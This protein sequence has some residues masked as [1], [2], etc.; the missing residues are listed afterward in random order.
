MENKKL[1]IGI[2]GGTFDPIH[3]GHLTIAEQVRCHFNL[4]KVLFVPT[5][6]PPHKDINN[7]TDPFH[8]LNMVKCAIGSNPYFEAVDIE[9]KREG[10][11]F[12]VDTLKQ[13]NS[14]YSTKAQFYYIIGADVV[15]DLLT[16]RN[17]EEVFRLTEFIAVMRPGFSNEEFDSQIK[18]LKEK[19]N[20]KLTTFQAP[21]IEISSTGI[22]DLITKKQSIKYM[23]P[24]C[25][26]DYICKNNL[27]LK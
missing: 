25:V 11:T 22:R 2:C 10:Y 7:V 20:I 16:W 26:E 27:Y 6:M 14:L 17:P 21:L 9:V 19:Y 12:A 5:G 4:D 13:L 15:M 23:V 8:R 18:Y 24:E 1:K 3:I